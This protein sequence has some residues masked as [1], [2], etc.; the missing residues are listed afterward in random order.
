MMPSKQFNPAIQEQDKTFPI[1]PRN[2]RNEISRVF[3]FLFRLVGWCDRAFHFP[4]S[5]SPATNIIIIIAIH[6]D[7]ERAQWNVQITPLFK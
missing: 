6:D 5:S 2:S 3:Y 1:H 7:K 4:S